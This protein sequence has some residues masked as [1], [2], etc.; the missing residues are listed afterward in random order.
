MWHAA[1]TILGLC[2]YDNKSRWSFAFVPQGRGVQNSEPLPADWHT[3]GGESRQGKYPDLGTPTTARVSNFFMRANQGY[4]DRFSGYEK[5]TLTKIDWTD[6]ADD[7]FCVRATFFRA[8][9]G[10]KE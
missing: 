2:I 9:F 8:W 10:I 1:K 7:S 5:E 3:L 6:F 4:G